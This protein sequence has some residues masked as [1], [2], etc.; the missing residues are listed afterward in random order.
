MLKNLK[1]K[2]M[3]A[4][5][6]ILLNGDIT[7]ENGYDVKKQIISEM[8]NEPTIVID[9]TSVNVIDSTGLGVMVSV[10]K[11]AKENGQTI[12]LANVN[13]K[14]YQIFELTRLNSIFDIE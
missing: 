7:S 10:L 13:T 14:V 6:K 4:L 5:N 3:K 8:K 11:K 9:F 12:K 1:P 2:E